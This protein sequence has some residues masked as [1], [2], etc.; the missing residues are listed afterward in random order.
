V[1]QGCKVAV[2]AGDR[3]VQ[4]KLVPRG[5]CVVQICEVAV[6]GVDGTMQEATAWLRQVVVGADGEGICTKKR[7]DVWHHN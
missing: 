5:D 4:A 2:Q 6:Q 1:V 7:G 3:A